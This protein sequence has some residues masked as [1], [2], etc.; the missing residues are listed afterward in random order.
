[1]STILSTHPQAPSEDNRR[2]S[3]RKPY[4]IEARIW[5]PTAVD[6]NEREEVRAVNLS[7]HGVAFQIDHAI[8]VAHFMMIEVGIGQQKITS[9]VR[10][11]SCRECD[12]HV[13]E[14]GAEFC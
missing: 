10:I 8:P 1:M 12:P 6:P 11:I 13:F 4:V 5:S 7:R 14:V 3:E 2:R 9:E